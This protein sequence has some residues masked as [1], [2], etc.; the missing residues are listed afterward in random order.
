VPPPCKLVAA[1]SLGLVA[2][3]LLI[4]AAHNSIGLP[5]MGQPRELELG[6]SPRARL[7][8]NHTARVALTSASIDCRKRAGT[9]AHMRQLFLKPLHGL[10]LSGLSIAGAHKTIARPGIESFI[11]SL[12]VFMS[13]RVCVSVCTGGV[14]IHFMV[15]NKLFVQ[16]GAFSLRWS[17]FRWRIRASLIKQIGP[18]C[19]YCCCPQASPRSP[20]AC[21]A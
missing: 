19:C 6:G 8:V 13:M 15:S 16:N 17:R 4:A 1:V 14:S 5:P 20:R 11:Q 18:R 9:T 7:R 10:Q 2:G 3:C 21:L 12:E